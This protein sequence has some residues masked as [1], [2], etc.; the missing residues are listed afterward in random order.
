M[1]IH[2]RDAIM[3]VIAMLAN[4]QHAIQMTLKNVKIIARFV[5]VRILING[6]YR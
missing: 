5:G 4:V 1:E 6:V 3:I 2:A